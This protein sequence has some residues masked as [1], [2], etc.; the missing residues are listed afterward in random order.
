LHGG[1][2]SRRVE[3][4]RALR[5]RSVRRTISAKGKSMKAGICRC[6]SGTRIFGVAFLRLLIVP[7]LILLTAAGPQVRAATPLITTP[8]NPPPLAPSSSSSSFDGQWQLIDDDSDDIVR[9]W[10]EA[11]RD[12]MKRDARRAPSNAPMAQPANPG[13]HINLPVFLATFKRIVFRSTPQNVVI[14]Q[15]HVLQ[16]E[17]L[18]PQRRQ[19]DENSYIAPD[20]IAREV[21]L[22]PEATSISLRES[23]RRPPTMFIGGWEK[24][25]LVIET[26]TDEGLLIEERWHITR[27]DNEEILHRNVRLRSSIWGEKIFEQQFGKASSS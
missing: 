4:K 6:A 19:H 24:G 17:P 16:P 12:H 10:H 25:T 23:A 26:T 22:H 5:L 2:L 11:I 21:N 20:A 8:P 13:Q 15:Q 7:M 9:L 3:P 14:E 18:Q 1:R 27:D